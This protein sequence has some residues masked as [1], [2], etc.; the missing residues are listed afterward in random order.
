VLPISAP[1]RV[2]FTY[3]GGRID[4]LNGRSRRLG[5]RRPVPVSRSLDMGTLT[6]DAGGLLTIEPSADFAPMPRGRSFSHAVHSSVPEPSGMALLLAAGGALL[7]GRRTNSVPRSNWRRCWFRLRWYRLGTSR[8][9]RPIMKIKR[10]S[11]IALQSSR[12]EPLGVWILFVFKTVA[13]PRPSR[14]CVLEGHGWRLERSVELG[15]RS[16]RQ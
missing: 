5:D 13:A 1:A 10:R 8:T 12:R 16:S 3:A 7:F 6:I 15:W 9:G 14:R 4:H 2:V 11:S